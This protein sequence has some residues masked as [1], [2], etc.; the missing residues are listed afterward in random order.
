MFR[1]VNNEAKITFIIHT[2]GPFAIR[3]EKK[4]VL[5]PT[6][7]DMQ[8][9]RS[10][11]HGSDTV[12]IPGSSLKGVM[13]SRFEKI[14]S[15]FGGKCC[16]IVDRRQACREPKAEREVNPNKKNQ[17]SGERVYQGVCIACKLFGS[18][19]LASRIRI[20]DAYPV[21]APVLGERTG[22]GINRITGAA[23][24]GALYDFE[25]VEEGSFKAEIFLKN[26]ELYQLQLILYV[27]K[28]LHEGYVSLGAASTRGNGRVEI[29][30][31]AI[32]F[33]EY[34]KE[35]KS[36]LVDCFKKVALQD[37][38]QYKL[39]YDWKNGFYGVDNK[40]VNLDQ[41]IQELSQNVSLSFS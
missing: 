25:V 9:L 27:L 30:D 17:S 14:V 15:L 29:R 20:S 32:E 39:D 11:Y 18:T 4:N 5:D 37:S 28:D 36:G 38:E 23:Q 35:V 22:V 10:R 33:R 8:C 19:H 41:L 3:T 21:T 1:E 24:R 13:R 31:V 34:R 7:P 26:Y 16:N 12:I 40:S 2:K 6:L